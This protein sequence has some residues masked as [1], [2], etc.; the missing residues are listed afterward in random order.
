MSKEALKIKCEVISW[1]DVHERS[2]R[3]ARKIKESGFQP[4]II[5]GLARGGWVPARN[6]CDFLGVK[7]LVSIKMEHWGDTATKDGNAK[8]K[9]PLN[10][11]LSGRKVLIADDVADTGES[12][13]VAKEH[14]KLLGSQEV[15]TATL[16]AFDST[17][18][19]RLADFYTDRLPW[20]WIVFP[21][22][23]TEDMINLM[24]KMVE[25]HERMYPDEIHKGMETY[26]DIKMEL[27][28]VKEFLKEAE[29]RKKLK[30]HENSEHWGTF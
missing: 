22:N 14:V 29:R 3:L 27:E 1:D 24:R 7:D 8:L 4:D 16:N 23:Y 12:L 10:I 30:K 21:W 2:K 26:F 5:I 13:H 9:H 20:T 18:D 6:L 17:P 11:N 15:K 19:N 25:H 28:D